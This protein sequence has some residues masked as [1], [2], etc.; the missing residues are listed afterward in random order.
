MDN[1]NTDS[2]VIVS[3][4]L[5]DTTTMNDVSVTWPFQ[6]GLDMSTITIA[7]SDDYTISS[8]LNGTGMY[9]Q[10]NLEVAGDITIAGQSL[11]ERL[12]RIEERLAILRP[13]P[14]M[15]KRWEQLR[16]LGEQ[17]RALEQ[18]LTEREWI[19]EQLKK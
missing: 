18:E 19:F 12:D 13:N 10:K 6:A 14:E 15:E 9:I 4:D 5:I 16:E 17:Y 11:S 2:I 1:S 7:G 3:D 8:S